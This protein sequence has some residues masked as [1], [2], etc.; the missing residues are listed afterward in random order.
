M[1]VT[2]VVTIGVSFT[3]DKQ[4]QQDFPTAPS[5]VATGN[6][7]LQDMSTGNNTIPVPVNAVGVLIIPPPA[8]T[9]VLKLNGT[10]GILISLTD[11]MYLSL[12]K[13]G[14]D[15]VVN[16]ASAVTGMRFIFS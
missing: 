5:S 16:A 4:Y 15:I 2:S 7:F 13:S 12:D 6:D 1:S 11:P 8:N 9:V 14:T 3:G 10:S